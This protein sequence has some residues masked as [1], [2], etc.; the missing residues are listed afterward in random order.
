MSKI[1]NW[2]IGRIIEL[3]ARQNMTV[4]ELADK[5]N[6]SPSTIQRYLNGKSIMKLDNIIK[7]ANELSGSLQKFLETMDEELRVELLSTL[8]NTNT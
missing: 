2:I 7:I 4:N 3:L 8:D 1:H 6:L 5:C